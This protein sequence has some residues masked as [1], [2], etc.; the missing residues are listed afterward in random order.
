MKPLYERPAFRRAVED[1][2]RPGGPDMTRYGLAHCG[3]VPG[4][5]VMDVGCGPGVTL[6]LLEES[7]LEAVGVD[8][9]SAMLREAARR[10][11]L[12]LAAGTIQRL[13]VRAACVDGVVCECVLSLSPSMREGLA[14]IR[15]VLRPGGR[16]LLT[17][18]VAREEGASGGEGCAAGAV[19]PEEVM[20]HLKDQR[21]RII[22]AEDHSRLLAE[23]A[24]RLLFQGVARSDLLAWMGRPCGGG[25]EGC[26]GKRWGYWLFIAEKEEE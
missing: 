1:C 5:R 18:I 15:R 24:G 20:G 16:L 3:F 11:G 4:Q 2:L 13:P 7:G 22:R 14:E 17:D 12:R 21:F 19:S 26:F 8:R 10:G 25:S 6:G 23:L 9:S